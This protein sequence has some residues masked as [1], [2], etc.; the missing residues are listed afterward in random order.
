MT[1]TDTFP[2]SGKK[3]RKKKLTQGGS[4]E[5][6]NSSQKPGKVR[7]EF[8]RWS[9]YFEAM[10]SVSL[11]GGITLWAYFEPKGQLPLLKCLLIPIL[12]DIFFTDT[13]RVILG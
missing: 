13:N 7:G 9:R 4:N 6:L 5:P 12:G 10:F 2:K 3:E 1:N 8:L 11:K